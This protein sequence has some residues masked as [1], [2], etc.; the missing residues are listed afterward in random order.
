MRQC[1]LLLLL[2]CCLPFSVWAQKQAL[3][4]DVYDGWREI[5]AHQISPDGQW[6]AYVLNPQDGDATLELF[7]QKTGKY[8]RFERGENPKISFDS[9]W[10]V[11]KISPQAD[12]LKAMRRRKVKKEDLPKDSL[13]IYDLRNGQ[14]QKIADVKRFEMPEKYAGW[15]A[16]WLEPEKPSSKKEKAEKDAT[17]D[18]TQKSKAEKAKKENAENG[19]KLVLL[20]L[21]TSARDTV[22]YATQFAFAEEAPAFA[23]VTKGKDSTFPEG[24][25]AQLL[26]QQRR[27]H[28]QAAKGDYKNLQW[29]KAGTQ[30]AFV[31]DTD[32]SANHK[33]ALLKYYDLYY[34]RD[35][36]A[37]AQRIAQAGQPAFPQEWMVS[38]HQQPMFSQDGRRLFFGIHPKP[39]VADTTLLPEEIVNVEVWHWQDGYLHTQQKANAE[40][41]KKRAYMAVYH[42]VDNKLLALATEERPNLSLGNEGNA[43]YALAATDVPYRRLSTWEGFPPYHDIYRVDV[44]TGAAKLLATKIKAYPQISP[45]G[46][47]A[48]WYN[49]QDSAWFAYDFE[50]EQLSNI[51]QA[52]A[53]VFYDERDDHPDYP[54][55]YGIAGWLENDAAL[56]AYDRYDLWQLDPQGRQAPIRLTTN[57]RENQTTYRYI[58]LD[59]EERFI[60]P[61]AQMLLHLFEE[62]SKAEGYAQLTLPKAAKPK[63]LLKEDFAFSNNVIKAKNTPDVLF[64]KQSFTQFPDVQLSDL[65]FKKQQRISRA[66]PQQDQYLWGS[67]V[68]VSWTA[69][70]GTPLE[71]MLY[72]PENFD[73]NKKYPLMVYFYERNA[74]N[75]HRHWA[76]API[77]SIINFSYFTSNGY[78]VFVPDIVYKD[79]YPGESAYNC[80][81]SGTEAM[82]KAHP[83]LNPERVGIQ[84]HSWGGYQTAY[85]VTRT[86]MFRAAEAGAPVSN[87]TSAYGGIRWESGLSRMFQ[88]EHSQSRIG[89][90][91][92]ERQDLYIENSPIFFADKINTPLLLLHNDEDGAVPW[93]QGIELY[94][95]LRRLDKPVW[96]LNYNGE[97]H[98]VMKRHNRKDFTKRLYQFFDHYLKDAPAPVWL[99]KGIPAIEKSLNTGLELM[100]E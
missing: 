16:Y 24:V 73:P 44:Q 100:E 88:Y 25:Y 11:F 12:T 53:T 62:K 28:I 42:I 56:I 52:A 14:L 71:G 22:W 63:V 5:Q 86:N 82:L 6:I 31:G 54:S 45:Q 57:G 30:L 60:R 7:N 66:N 68:P 95:A 75:I 99:E 48:Y 19:S 41:E 98:G 20:N 3:T 37:E 38:E 23:F 50:R 83:Y 17:P 61:N 97:A 89:A 34:W 80:I 15:M 91:L 1:Y 10:L 13:G 79:G 59:P 46:R 27:A 36:Q 85:L 92:W 81:I 26:T 35:G 51:S 2:A 93:Y 9:R 77:R 96:M 32:T 29:D 39:L 55:A 94:V 70:D 78:F 67:V 64:T 84:G 74:E 21:Q 65:G 43:R 90:T 40:R 76:P 8:T 4:H 18:S 58:R 47:Y 33:K 69:Y 87:M 49:V 72:R